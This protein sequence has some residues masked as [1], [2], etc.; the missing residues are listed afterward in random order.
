MCK[1]R[2]VWKGLETFINRKIDEADSSVN[3]ALILK[4]VKVH[5]DKSH[6]KAK[7]HKEGQEVF[8]KETNN[9]V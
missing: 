9:F 3:T 4:D 7:K 5:D 6:R 8:G 2:K 1:I